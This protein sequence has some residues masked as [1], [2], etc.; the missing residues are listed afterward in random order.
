MARE[1]KSFSSLTTLVIAML[2]LQ[3]IPTVI[4][5][6]STLESWISQNMKEHLEM[7]ANIA[8]SFN[9]TVLDQLLVK[10]EEGGVKVIKV[11]KDSGGD[12]DKVASAVDNIPLENN[13]RAVI[14]IDGG[15]KFE[16]ITI[17]RTKNLVTLCG[18]PT[19]IPK[20]V[21]NGR[22]VEFDTLNSA[23][24]VMESDYF[25]VVNIA[26]VVTVSFITSFLIYNYDLSVIQYNIEQIFENTH[27]DFG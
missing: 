25:A 4:S 13:Q 14:W 23:T 16:K 12:F 18:D 15:E 24:V 27:F 9:L 19:E 7:K 20:I 22:T 3:L 17:D 1:M 10:A 8:H 6:V 5:H 11:K 21:F 26:F 2:A